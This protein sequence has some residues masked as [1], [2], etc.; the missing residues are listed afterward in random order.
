MRTELQP[1]IHAELRQGANRWREAD[2]LSYPACPM[3]AIALHAGLSPTCDRAKEWDSLLLGREI[4]QRFLQGLRSRPHQG[5]VERMVNPNEPRENALLLQ[6]ARDA[7]LK[8]Y[9]DPIK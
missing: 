2:R 7:P 4:G 5:V 6:I 3:T 1:N 8:R 9:A